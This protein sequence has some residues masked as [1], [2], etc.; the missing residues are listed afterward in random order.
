[1]DVNKFKARVWDM[2]QLR[3]ARNIV[4]DIHVYRIDNFDV[5]LS[6]S[7]S[8]FVLRFLLRVP[9]S[10]PYNI[11]ITR[12]YMELWDKDNSPERCAEAII[13]IC[14]NFTKLYQVPMQSL[15][16]QLKGMVES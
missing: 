3:V 12:E 7:G 8:Y 2:L 14:D 10:K 15:Y 1:M 16:S 5:R 4:S 6:L 9:I 11:D 13:K